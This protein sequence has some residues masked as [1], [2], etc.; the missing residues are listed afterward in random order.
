[1][2]KNKGL[3]VFYVYIGGLEMTLYVFLCEIAA[4]KVTEK[5]EKSPCCLQRNAMRRLE[6]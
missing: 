5:S 2:K 3:K 6:Y 4:A 1:M